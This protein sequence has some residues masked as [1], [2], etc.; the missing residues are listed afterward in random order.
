M[1]SMKESLQP[2]KQEVIVLW[3]K[4]QTVWLEKFDIIYKCQKTEA[5]GWKMLLEKCSETYFLS[6]SIGFNSEI[7][8][9]TRIC[10]WMS[11]SRR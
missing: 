7:E 4:Y 9:N 2:M 5:N 1:V 8:I 11:F 3:S 6:L 10:H